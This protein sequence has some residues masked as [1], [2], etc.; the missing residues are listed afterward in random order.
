MSFGGYQ[1][2]INHGKIQSKDLSYLDELTYYHQIKEFSEKE[3]RKAVEYNKLLV[4]QSKNK[5]CKHD[6]CRLRVWDDG[7]CYLHHIKP[8][9]INLIDIENT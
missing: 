1:N 3:L 6:C 9:D 8:Q 7:V 2:K 4:L 5:I